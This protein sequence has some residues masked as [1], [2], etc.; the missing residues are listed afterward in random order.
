MLKVKCQISSFLG[1]GFLF[2]CF[3]SCQFVTPITYIHDEREVSI[4]LPVL[5]QGC[6]ALPFLAPPFQP[7]HMNVPQSFLC[8]PLAWQ[9]VLPELSLELVADDA[10]SLEHDIFLF[11]M[12][13]FESEQ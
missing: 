3:N 9:Q 11:R 13:Q 12:F 7:F 4:Y 5:F 1:S 2:L 6:T 10:S 8:F